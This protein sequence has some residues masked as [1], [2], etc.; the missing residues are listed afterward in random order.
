LCLNHCLSPEIQHPDRIGG[1]GDKEAPRITGGSIQNPAN[2]KCRRENHLNFLLIQSCRKRPQGRMQVQRPLSLVEIQAL[3]L[4]HYQ[5]KT[6]TDS[7]I[8]RADED[9][10]RGI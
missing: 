5:M 1:G 7:I 6:K 4:L 2:M 10:R 3:P 8:K 9:K